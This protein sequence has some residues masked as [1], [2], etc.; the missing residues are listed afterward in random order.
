MCVYFSNKWPFIVNLVECLYM[1]VKQ[2]ILILNGENTAHILCNMMKIYRKHI[3]CCELYFCIIIIIFCIMLNLDFMNSIKTYNTCIIC[4]KMRQIECY[5]YL[6]A[7]NS[8]Q[9]PYHVENT[10]SRPI[11]EEIGRASCRERVFKDV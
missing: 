11:T 7:W 2:Y 5:V 4:I 3:K 9:R 8:C 1:C 6:L 10:G